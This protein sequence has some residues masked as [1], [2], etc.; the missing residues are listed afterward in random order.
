MLKPST[1]SSHSGATRRSERI[2]ANEMPLNVYQRK[3]ALISS[4][5]SV[6][7]ALRLLVLAVLR[8]VVAVMR[9]NPRQ[10]KRLEAK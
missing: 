10:K 6:F 7:R 4:P 5:G 8:S 2:S 9:R 3:K 1:P